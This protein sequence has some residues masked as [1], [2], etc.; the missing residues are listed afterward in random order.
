MPTSRI[1]RGGLDVNPMPSHDFRL[2]CDKIKKG[3][4][5]RSRRF[6]KIREAPLWRDCD[7]PPSFSDERSA[8]SQEPELCFG[9]PARGDCVSWACRFARFAR[10][11]SSQLLSACE[12]ADH[13]VGRLSNQVKVQMWASACVPSAESSRQCSGELPRTRSFGSGESQR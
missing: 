13:R 12:V 11:S 6:R 9:S 1:C 8:N 7:F 3:P 10:C 2:R 5:D 4:V